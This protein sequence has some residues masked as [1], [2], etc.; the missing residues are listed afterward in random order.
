MEI[1]SI[2]VF[3]I[4]IGAKRKPQE[5]VMIRG[6]SISVKLE[7][8]AKKL[9]VSTCDSNKLVGSLRSGKWEFDSEQNRITFSHLKKL[10]GN[11]IK[12]LVKHAA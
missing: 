5:V 3:G 11:D 9:Y 7:D 2:N 1:N 12:R 4:I 8:G 10:V 6:G